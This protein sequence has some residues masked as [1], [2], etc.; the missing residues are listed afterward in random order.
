MPRLSPNGRLARSA[1][2]T[3]TAIALG[4]PMAHAAPNMISNGGFEDPVVPT[5]SFTIFET[6]AT[7]P[8]WT[9]MGAPGNVAVVNTKYK[10]GGFK[11]KALAGKQWLDLTGIDGN[12]ATGVQQT[13]ATSIGI[14]YQLTFSVGNVVDKN[15]V[16]GSKSTIKVLVNGDPLMTAVNPGKKDDGTIH[17]KTFN[18]VVIGTSKRTTIA[19]VNSDP[20]TD[21]HNALDAVSLI[22]VVAAD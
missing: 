2:L 6:D 5:G 8:S 16:F 3:V 21:N 12:G 4:L 15:N 20:S 17:W 10:Q 7:F 18:T 1:A 9:V 13:V 11:F 22:P 19:F 14:A